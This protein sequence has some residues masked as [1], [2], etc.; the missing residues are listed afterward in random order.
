M[1]HSGVP[2]V[3]TGIFKNTQV[4]TMAVDALALCVDSTSATMTLAI[5]FHEDV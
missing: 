3:Q 5:I 2:S 1:T 4:N